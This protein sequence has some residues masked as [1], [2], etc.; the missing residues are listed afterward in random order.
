MPCKVK[1]S[2]QGF[3][4]GSNVLASENIQ[5]VSQN[6]FYEGEN[7]SLLIIKIF[8][9]INKKDAPNELASKCNCLFDLRHQVNS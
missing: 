2:T 3:L 7:Q 8:K 1:D 6:A 4:S 5:T 9:K